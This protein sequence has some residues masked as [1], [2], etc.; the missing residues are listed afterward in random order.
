MVD[1]PPSERPTDE[2]LR[3]LSVAAVYQ[4]CAPRVYVRGQPT[5]DPRNIV[6][7]ARLHRLILGDFPDWVVAPFPPERTAAVLDQPELFWDAQ[8]L[9]PFDEMPSVNSRV[10]L[11]GRPTLTAAHLLARSK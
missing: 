2:T 8:L 5:V 4:W 7:I 3:W 10:Y 11:L 6:P 1:L 9:I